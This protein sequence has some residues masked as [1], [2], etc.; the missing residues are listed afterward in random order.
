MQYLRFKP[1]ERLLFFIITLVVCALVGSIF[2]GFIVHDGITTKSLRLATVIQDCVIFILPAVITAVIISALPARF[3][4]IDSVFSTR[5]LILAVVAMLVSIPLM[6]W[7]VMMNDS[8]V[9]PESLS[10]L[11]EWMRSHEE[12]ARNSVKILLGGDSIGSLVIDLLIVGVLAG[13][14]EEILFR[15]ALQQL[16]SSSGMNRHL[17]IWLTAVIF[18]AI[19]MQF[20]GFVPRLLLGAYFGYLLW[21]SN[22]LWL[23]AII[24]ALNNSIVVYSTWKYSLASQ[25]G[26]DNPIDHWGLDSPMLIAASAILTLFV[27]LRLKNTQIESGSQPLAGG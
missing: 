24:H 10:G 5:Q 1:S 7:I 11:E 13:L 17:A 14:S 16:F 2:V 20:F 21:W 3:L 8:L 26:G 15:G 9:L 23:P 27:V 25:G 12:E 6:N 19:H 22:S 4:R 18:S